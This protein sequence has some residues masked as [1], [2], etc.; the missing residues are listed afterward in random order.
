[1]LP[2]LCLFPL[3][4]AAAPTV[5]DLDALR[6]AVADAQPGDVITLSP[7]T[8]VLNQTLSLQAPGQAEAPIRLIAEGATLES[9]VVE[10]IKVS[11]PHWQIEGLRLVGVCEHAP[12]KRAMWSS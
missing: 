12:G 10:A 9:A 5:S 7:G 3:A 1:M 2:L 8:Y 4:I 11:G 6:L